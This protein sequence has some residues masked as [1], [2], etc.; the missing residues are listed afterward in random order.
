MREM[1]VRGV[2]D[3]VD[4]LVEEIA[5]HHLENVADAARPGYFFLRED[6]FL[7]GTFAQIYS[8][9]AFALSPRTSSS[10]LPWTSC[11]WILGFTSA[12][13]G[14]FTGRTSS[15]CMT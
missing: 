13:A 14:N 3:R 12:R 8:T 9:L 5:P 7:R 1:P 6:F 15:S 11:C 4:R 10:I 2:D